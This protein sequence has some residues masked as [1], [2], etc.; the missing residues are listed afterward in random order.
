MT[1]NRFRF[2]AWDKDIKRYW[3]PGDF[4]LQEA[5]K[6]K[7]LIIEQCTGL[8]DKNGRLIYEGD[9]ITPTLDYNEDKVVAEIKFGNAND[10]LGFY[11][12]WHGKYVEETKYNPG[13]RKDLYFWLEKGI[14][15]VGNIHENPAL[16]EDN[17]GVH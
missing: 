14:E 17:N 13:W 12:R 9:I 6:E 1:E 4:D 7:Y 10:Y 16:L 2:R 15:V 8:K 11:P 3:E 5:C